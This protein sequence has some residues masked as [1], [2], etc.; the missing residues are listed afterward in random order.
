MAIDPYYEMAVFRDPSL[1]ATR[2]SLVSAWGFNCPTAG[3][4]RY[5]YM[6]RNPLSDTGSVASSSDKPTNFWGY[7]LDFSTDYVSISDANQDGLDITGPMTMSCWVQLDPQTTSSYIVGKF[8]GG[9]NARCYLLYKRYSGGN[10]TFR[11]YVSGDGVNT[12]W[13]E[14]AAVSTG[15][16][17]HIV[18]RYVPST[19]ISIFVDG[20]EYINTTSIPASI[21]DGSADFIVGA[22]KSGGVPTAYY[23][24]HVDE[25]YVWNTALSDDLVSR[26]YVNTKTT[27]PPDPR[28]MWLFR[29]FFLDN[30]IEAYSGDLQAVWRM[31]EG[32]SRRWE[33][34]GYLWLGVKSGSVG[35]TTGMKGF[36]ASFNGVGSN[37]LYRA[38]ESKFQFATD[39]FTISFWIKAEHPASDM[40]IGGKYEA[41]STDR[42]YLYRLLADGTIGFYVYYST[43]S[44]NVS[45]VSTN[46]IKDN[47]WSHVVLRFEHSAEI[48]VFVDG[49]KTT[50]TTSIPA[51]I[52]AGSA[53][54]TVGGYS[55][56]H[57]LTGAI[58]E[59]YLWRAA[60]SDSACSALYND[61]NGRFFE[62]PYR[63]ANSVLQ[64]HEQYF[65]RAWKLDIQN[66]WRNDPIGYQYLIRAA[67][68]PG[69]ATGK[70]DY[71]LQTDRTGSSV[72]LQIGTSYSD[73]QEEVTIS[74]WFKQDEL[75]YNGL[76]IGDAGNSNQEKCCVGITNT[77]YL[78]VRVY[79]SAQRNFQSASTFTD[80]AS[81]HHLVLVVDTVNQTVKLWI[82]NTLWID[83][84]GTLSGSPITVDTNITLVGSGFFG[85]GWYYK[86]QR[87]DEIYIWH[88][89]FTA[90]EVA[91]LY[92][93]G[94]GEFIE[95]FRG[96]QESQINGER[97]MRVFK[98][99]EVIAERGWLRDMRESQVD[100]ERG[101]YK[102]TESH[103]VFD[104][105]MRAFKPSY[106]F[107][108][109]GISTLIGTTF[110]GWRNF[111]RI[112]QNQINADRGWLRDIYTTP[113]Y[114]ER[115]IYKTT[116]SH[117][118]FERYIRNTQESPQIF[119]RGWYVL[120]QSQ[121]HAE[122]EYRVF[123]PSNNIF[124]RAYRV[125]KP[126]YIFSEREIRV[127]V[128]VGAGPEGGLGSRHYFTV[129]G[130]DVYIDGVWKGFI[131]FARGETTLPGIPLADGDHILELRMSKWFWPRCR[132]TKRYYFTVTGGELLPKTA[133]PDV[134]DL[135]YNVVRAVVNLTWEAVWNEEFTEPDFTGFGVWF[136]A[137]SPVPIS[138]PPAA[139]VYYDVNVA[140]YLLSYTP[141]ASHYVR[142]AGYKNSERGDDEEIFVD[143][144]I[145]PPDSPENQYLIET[146]YQV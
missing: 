35:Y 107:A 64:Q 143:V 74:C 102:V 97:E 30:T 11:F 50:N 20:T 70:D 2:T 56:T 91:A 27:I 48:T 80:T 112:T 51:T 122:R 24:G 34:C 73:G 104:R 67:G 141:T 111:Y 117:N 4:T 90:T 12:V 29:G 92:N 3:V 146:I 69:Y 115:G 103:N 116:E 45:V 77:N 134:D 43:D 13:A 75:G 130:A 8:D 28:Q 16:W 120:T 6:R 100:A 79:D 131:D 78:R 95:R 15:V 144:G 99:S 114:A 119:N 145:A 37:Y 83:D 140:R 58:D 47:E 105:Q 125:F 137:T 135:Q 142:V 129:D 1:E 62:R 124:I 139:T 71:A 66:G 108:K 118:I 42:E 25:L 136:S 31:E 106:I 5:D 126:S 46:S 65:V 101:I 53:D 94:D 87:V 17:Y 33:Q 68:E 60:I 55:T 81:W 18:C 123:R 110:E 23:D 40:W 14:S 113:I 22:A 10:Y 138:G 72:R 54:F 109:R 59:F 98:P 39:P 132:T 26:L 38:S 36:A 121:L 19:E 89:A 21:F 93:D 128:T 41:T 32:G 9:N 63:F 44:S 82:D 52:N 84:T 88:K 76:I 133:I 86:T 57:T 127:F 7:S 61:D 85:G 96:E 49:V